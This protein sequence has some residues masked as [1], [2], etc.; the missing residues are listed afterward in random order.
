MKWWVNSFGPSH[1]SWP[2]SFKPI[3]DQKLAWLWMM[4][5][6]PINQF[7]KAFGG[8][9][10]RS[11]GHEEN[12]IWWVRRQ[13]GCNSCNN[14]LQSKSATLGNRPFLVLARTYLLSISYIFHTLKQLA[15][16]CIGMNWQLVWSLLFP[17][18]LLAPHEREKANEKVMKNVECGSF[19]QSPP[20]LFW[21]K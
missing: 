3:R 12:E 1:G 17:L 5:I 2:T 14:F 21:G 8:H 13:L 7:W 11:G 4:C 9:N 19:N 20:I 18:S 15:V 16:A 10:N 6:W